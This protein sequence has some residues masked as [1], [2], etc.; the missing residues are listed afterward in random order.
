MTFNKT[1]EYQLDRISGEIGRSSLGRNAVPPLHPDVVPC[2]PVSPEGAGGGVMTAPDAGSGDVLETCFSAHRPP[3]HPIS[4]NSKGKT[5][6]DT[7]HVSGTTA[8]VI[9]VL[10][11]TPMNAGTRV[12]TITSVRALREHLTG[13]PE[14]SAEAF[15]QVID[16]PMSDLRSQLGTHHAQIISD[17]GRAKRAWSDPF[18]RNLVLRM[19]GQLPTLKDAQEAAQA[20]FKSDQAKRTIEALHQLA[21]SRATTPDNIIATAVVIEPLLRTLIPEDLGVHTK[22]SLSNKISQIRAAVKLVDPNAISG[23]EADVKALPEVWQAF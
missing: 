19:R 9:S 22:K 12:H 17:V 16:G 23:R 10:R 6:L 5:M 13:G 21:L 15:F 4:L 7:T 14:M 2:R 8:D 3:E 20:S 18:R 11:L 1:V